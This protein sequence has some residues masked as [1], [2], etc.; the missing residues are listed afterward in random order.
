MSN[1]KPSSQSEPQKLEPTERELAEIRKYLDRRKAAPPAPRVKVSKE[2]TGRMLSLDHPDRTVGSALLFQ[3]LGTT[4]PDFLNGL[5]SQLA[6]VGSQGREVDETGLNF[7]LSIVK[8]A[9]PRDQFEA[10]LAAQMAAIHTT[11]M[12]FAKRLADVETIPQQDSAERALNKLARTFAMQL[13]ALRRYRTGGEQRVTVQHVSVNEGGRAIVGSVTP[14]PRESAPAELEPA[15]A[16]S[17][18][19]DPR[20]PTI[21]ASTAPERTTI[22]FPRRNKRGGQSSS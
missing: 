21:T 9:K 15:A 11:I 8:D 13:E 14:A 10:M 1:E 3:A 2:K 18:L 12:T 4:D 17:A 16:A 7:L 20:R 6:N 22:P 19:P 5:L